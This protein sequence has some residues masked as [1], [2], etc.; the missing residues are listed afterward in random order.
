M[1]ASFLAL[2][3]AVLGTATASNATLVLYHLP[4]TGNESV[5]LPCIAA[6]TGLPAPIVPI[7]Y[8]AMIVAMAIVIGGLWKTLNRVQHSVDDMKEELLGAEEDFQRIKDIVGQYHDHWHQNRR[9]YNGAVPMDPVLQVSLE[10]IV[11]IVDHSSGT[12]VD[13]LDTNRSDVTSSSSSPS[14]SASTTFVNGAPQWKRRP[15]S[16]VKRQQR[17]VPA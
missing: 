16:V 8:I 7:P 6:P 2:G 9:T 13:R 1:L 3:M 4:M 17:S 11:R 15:A 10:N 14:P 5:A 12:D